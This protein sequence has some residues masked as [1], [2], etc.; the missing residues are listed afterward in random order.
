MRSASR[1]PLV[2]SSSVRSPLRSSSALVATVVPIFT[3]PTRPAGIGSPA[4]KA[5]QVADAL[6]GGVAIGLRV[7][8]QELVGDQRAVRPPADHVGEGAAAVDPEIPAAVRLQSWLRFMRRLG[9]RAV[10]ESLAHTSLDASSASRNP[11][12]MRKRPDSGCSGRDGPS[13]EWRVTGHH[14]GF[15]RPAL[16]LLPAISPA[17]S[18]WRSSC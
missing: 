15:S 17:R 10:A 14:A 1:K 16:P 3:A 18:W 12:I 4:C 9:L 2:V 6:D 5:E 11:A 13:P 8:R 7:L